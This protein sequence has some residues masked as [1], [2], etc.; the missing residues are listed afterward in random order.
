MNLVLPLPPLGNRYKQFDRRRGFYYRTK[1][2]DQYRL[3]TGKY[4]VARGLWPVPDGV[5][6]AV[7]VRIYRKRRAG[8]IDGYL[9]VLL[10]VLQ[11]VAYVNDSQVVELHAWRGDDKADPRVEVEIEEVA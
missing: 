6:V 5:R 10:D 2:A 3:R 4:A 1:E 7:S 8:D 11:G 9:K